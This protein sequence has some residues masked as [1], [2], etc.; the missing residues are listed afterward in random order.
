M[1]TAIGERRHSPESSR[2]RSSTVALS[3]IVIGLVL[4]VIS[5]FSIDLSKVNGLGFAAAFTPLTWAALVLAIAGSLVTVYFV[6]TTSANFWRL[7]V[8]ALS[9]AIAVIHGTPMVLESA[10]RFF[11]AYNHV[12]FIDYIAQTGQHSVELNNRLSWFGAFGAGATLSGTAGL[13]HLFGAIRVFPW[14]FAMVILLPVHS[15]LTK[16]VADQRARAAALLL[17]IIGNWIGQDYF[18]PQAIAYFMSMTTV[19][20]ILHLAPSSGPSVR[21]LKAWWA[22]RRSPVAPLI[23]ATLFTVAIVLAHQL[24]PV[25][26]IAMVLVV[27]L[28]GATS[29]RSFWLIVVAIFLTWFTV[30][31]YFFWGGHLAL[32]FGVHQE[33]NQSVSLTTIIAQNLTDRLQHGGLEFFV[34]IARVGLAGVYLS[35]GAWSTWK[36]RRSRELRILGVL[37]IAPFFFL[38]ATG[39]GGEALLRAVFFALPFLSGL[40][41][42]LM[43]RV[44]P[45]KMTIIALVVALSLLASVT[46]IA[47]YGNEKFERISADQLSTMEW[48]YNSIPTGSR[49]LYFGNAAPLNF[50]KIQDS[51]SNYMCYFHFDKDG[52]KGKYANDEILR[53]IGSFAPD[54]IVW[55]PESADFSSHVYRFPIG[56]D[57]PA[58]SYLTSAGNG[59]LVVNRPDIKIISFDPSWS[60]RRGVSGSHA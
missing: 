49:V 9:L 3:I 11:E 46:E 7:M 17:F 26:L 58:L 59:V 39:Y 37:S 43:L 23:L 29:L 12:G 51:Y 38:G 24:S 34:A 25:M 13:P 31:G 48:F 30:G 57:K 22:N 15:I 4:W 45:K 1:T 2:E 52:P 21:R 20:L 18:S 19:A 16:F 53:Q 40:I 33:S 56:W 60:P 50:T 44:K 5:L 32:L 35:L 47:R 8:G 10:P 54:M 42:I 36:G 55:T 14:L 27:V 6:P 41:G 28:S